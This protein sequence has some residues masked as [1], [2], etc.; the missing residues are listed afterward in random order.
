MSVMEERISQTRA[1]CHPRC[2]ETDKEGGRGGGGVSDKVIRWSYYHR[3][4][5]VVLQKQSTLLTAPFF[6]KILL[7][8]AYVEH[9]CPCTVL[10]T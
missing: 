4:A 7:L 8:T 6:L 2:N 3:T 5:S 9:A 1:N 10:C